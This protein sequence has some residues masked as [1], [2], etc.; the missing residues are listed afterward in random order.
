MN[1]FK[2]IRYFRLL[3]SSSLNV[4]LEREKEREGKS[5]IMPHK[6]SGSC[7]QSGESFAGSVRSVTFSYLKI[8]FSP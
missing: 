1:Y 7:I 5:L 3:A 8:L 2:A 6:L 4:F